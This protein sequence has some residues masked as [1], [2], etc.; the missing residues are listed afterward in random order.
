MCEWQ[1]KTTY[2]MISA[3]YLRWHEIY[4]YVSCPHTLHLSFKSTCI[5]QKLCTH[6]TYYQIS[7]VYINLVKSVRLGKIYFIMVLSTSIK[8]EKQR[9][10]LNKQEGKFQEQRCKRKWK[11][12]KQ[13]NW[14]H[15]PSVIFSYFKIFFLFNYWN[16]YFW[17]GESKYHFSYVEI[18]LYK[19]DGNHVL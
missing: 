13:C 10:A 17:N 6:N 18:L 16:Y 19:Y 7:M 3:S 12:F 9:N 2:D 11:C 5:S 15:K 14:Y 8:T 4:Q 1:T